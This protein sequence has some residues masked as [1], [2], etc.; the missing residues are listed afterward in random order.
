MTRLL[1]FD[2]DGTLLDTIA[3]LGEACNY[4]LRQ[5]GY[6]ERP[7][8]EYPKLVGNGVNKLIERALPEGHK[9]LDTVLLLKADFITYY[10]GHNRIHTHPYEGIPA[11]LA[12]AKRRGIRLAVASN[13]Y[14]EATQ[15]LILH[16]FGEGMFDVVLGERPGVERKPDPQIVSDILAAPEMRGIERSETLY[17]GD[18]DVDMQTAHNAHLTSIGCT[19]GFCA[20]EKLLAAQPDHLVDH[21]SEITKFLQ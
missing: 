21:P 19:W 7:A 8:C 15:A 17:I 11:L 2:L 4:A 13:K 20:R 9:D 18:S 14:N 3:D 10:N 1:I 5:H 6:A 12:E 16:Y